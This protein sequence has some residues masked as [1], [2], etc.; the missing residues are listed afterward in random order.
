[1]K[2]KITAITCL[3]VAA[4]ACTA[5]AEEVKY[6]K[7]PIL[8]PA[9]QAGNSETRELLTV[10][11]TGLFATVKN[12][13]AI[14]RNQK[15]PQTFI[16]LG[17][18]G[19]SEN[20]VRISGTSGATFYYTSV[21]NLNDLDGENVLSFEVPHDDTYN[22][23]GVTVEMI[24]T[25]DPQNK[26][27][28][29]WF[30]KSNQLLAN[31]LINC[32]GISKG[33][34]NESGETLGDP[35]VEYG[36]TAYSVSFVEHV[37]VAN[38]WGHL[39]FH[40]AYDVETQQVQGKFRATDKANQMYLDLDDPVQMGEENV[41]E[42]FTTGEVYLK[43][44]LDDVKSDVG[45]IVLTDIGGK[46]LAGENVKADRSDIINVD[47][48]AEYREQGLPQGQKDKPYTVP[49]ALDFDLLAGEISVG[50]QITA[51][52]G[53]TTVVS[54]GVYTP[55]ETGMHEIL[56]A[57]K[58]VNGFNVSEKYA[59]EVVE[60]VTE[61]NVRSTVPNGGTLSS[62]SRIYLPTVYTE[63]GSGVADVKTEYVFNGETVT[64][65]GDGCYVFTDD[66]TLKITA[67]ARDYLGTEKTAEFTYG[68]SKRTVITLFSAIPKAL[69]AETDY[70]LP[71][72]VG[73]V[74]GDEAVE[75]SKGITVNGVAVGSDRKITVPKTGTLN[76][77]YTVGAG[78]EYEARESYTVSVANE[79]AV[80]D[81]SN[82]F[83]VNE[84]ANVSMHATGVQ[85]GATGMD[86]KVEFV[87][88][89]S[90][91]YAAMFFRYP[92][93]PTKPVEP[94]VK[95]GEAYEA[96]LTELEAYT[97]A[98]A[99][100]QA[101]GKF[102]YLKITLTDV[103]D[104]EN[105]VSFRV[106]K[107][108]M[109]ADNFQ[110]K[111]KNGEYTIKYKILPTKKLDAAK[112][113]QFFYD[114]DA[115]KVYN[116]SN[117]EVA[118]LKYRND[119]KIFTGFAQ[120]AMYVTVELGNAGDGAK[121]WLTRLGNQN[122]D[123][124]TLAAGDIGKPQLATR[125]APTDG[126]LPLGYA[127]TAQKAMALDVLQPYSTAKVSLFTPDGEKLVN[128]V[129]CTSDRT[130]TLD[131]IGIYRLVYRLEDAAGNIAN[132]EYLIDVGDFTPPT[133][134]LKGSY[135][136]TYRLGESVKLLDVTLFDEISSDP[137]KI[138][139]YVIVYPS[140]YMPE[141]KK[142]G[143]RYVFET[144]GNYK[145]TYCAIDEAGNYTLLN[146]EIYVK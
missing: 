50:C 5:C 61:L 40:F 132:E 3:A 73:T 72:F 120:G 25:Y 88:P 76:I 4:L 92:T 32:N 138:V 99:E 112:R 91:N 26:V 57:T 84:R 129:A 19:L 52:S 38:G 122:L 60:Q 106:Y 49:K 74:V 82:L 20:G 114:N 90:A 47:M 68:V 95:E 104:R 127:L 100:Y 21:V 128:N 16:D 6:E 140:D 67:S 43:F 124:D 144:E 69:K 85:F 46:S 146:V 18:E 48:R 123:S 116:S 135:K 7:S 117:L 15:I 102:E 137:S 121:A 98:L 86:A 105:A 1:M 31:V 41:F 113:L 66:G 53:K 33:N 8:P 83:F 75:L 12:V 126:S 81:I 79:N 11:E 28:V 77:V 107:D 9:I 35:R 118:P 37:Y 133:I 130:F 125:K 103:S 115:C 139:L 142:V 97:A 110:I 10:D 109:L 89:I 134:T 34:N 80:G 78:T 24:D 131:Q 13:T 44:T 56:Y 42:G 23:A 36:V 111:D 2:K 101:F 108:N 17:V 63:G 59:F 54:D 58:D 65:D 94:E 55:T 145:I 143:D 141:Y 71:D 62:G 22:L 119:G 64:P 39:P 70:Y 93:S 29:Q 45:A 27:S 136:T 51:P 87:N 30:I 96:Y 14:E